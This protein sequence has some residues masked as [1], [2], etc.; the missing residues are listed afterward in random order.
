M[1]LLVMLT[2]RSQ[3]VDYL[4]KE[5]ARLEREMKDAEA[6]KKY[7]EALQLAPTDVKAL[8][9]CSEMNSVIGNRETD[10]KTKKDHFSA[11]RTYA[12]TALKLDEKDADA[13]YAMALSLAKLSSAGGVRERMDAVKDIKFH[14]DKALDA[15][16]GHV[17]SLHLLGKWNAEVTSF[18]PAEK[19]ALKIAF[20]GLPSTSYDRAIELMEACR[21]RSPNYLVNY[22]DLARAYRSNRQSDKAIEILNRMIK[23]PPRTADDN[24]YKAEGR[25]LLESL[26]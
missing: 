23:L 21:R 7:M 10:P 14:L 15:D 25:K 19:A 18:N 6:L 11:A 9:K 5:G 17:R 20:G 12:G 22:L 4:L 1:P 8:A 26:L 2:A 24:G 3:D 16:S 13:H